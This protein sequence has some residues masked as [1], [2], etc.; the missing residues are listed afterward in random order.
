M[1]LFFLLS[2]VNYIVQG[3][4]EDVATPYL[5]ISWL[6]YYIALGGMFHQ[7]IQKTET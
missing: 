6:T 4:A 1:N 7:Q 3:L 5:Y 2:T